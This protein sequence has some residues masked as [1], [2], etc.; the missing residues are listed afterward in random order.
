MD[1]GAPVKKRLAG[2]VDEVSVRGMTTARRRMSTGQRPVNPVGYPG[3]A[4]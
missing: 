2:L 3:V 4:R 1:L